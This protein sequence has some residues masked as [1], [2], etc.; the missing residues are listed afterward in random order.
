MPVYETLIFVDLFNVYA[1]TLNYL[2]QHDQMSAT[3]GNVTLTFSSQSLNGDTDN[4]TN[5]EVEIGKKTKHGIW[6]TTYSKP[7][8]SF[9]SASLL[10]HHYGW[11][12]NGYYASR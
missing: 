6:F 5:G 12:I 9:V 10:F 11:F 2:R 3:S 7:F 1:T 4:K 8:L